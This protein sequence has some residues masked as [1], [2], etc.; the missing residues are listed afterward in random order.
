MSAW[1]AIFFLIAAVVTLLTTQ[2]SGT[3][4][5]LSTD[6]FVQVT[7]G[8]AVLV[9]LSGMVGASYRGQIFQAVKHFASWAA[10][11]F[12][13]VGL[14]AYRTELATVA[15]HL[16]QEVADGLDH[17]AAPG[18]APVLGRSRRYGFDR[19]HTRWLVHRAWCL[20]ADVGLRC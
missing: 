8:I 10:M 6:T 7:A 14:Y 16:L 2:D 5:G 18:P 9:F 1:I 15:G 17:D 12:L 13:L 3:V 4:A 19:G 20:G 11:L